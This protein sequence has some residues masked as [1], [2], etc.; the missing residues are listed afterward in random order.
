MK[1]IATLSLLVL[2]MF[3]SLNIV[4]AESTPAFDMSYQGDKKSTELETYPG[5]SIKLIYKITNMDEKRSISI[6]LTGNGMGD[7]PMMDDWLKAEKESETV[8]L[9]KQETELAMNISIPKDAKL[10][11]YSGS[12]KG[13][14]TNYGTKIETKV[15]TSGVAIGTAIGEQIYVSVKSKSEIEGINSSLV[16]GENGQA[17]G[18][19][20]NSLIN[21]PWF[22]MAILI[23]IMSILG[24]IFIFPRGKE[25]K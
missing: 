7:N 12:I 2:L 10:E 17:E 14:M 22:Q 1:K 18:T 23:I 20:G 21:K 6:K 24:A 16:S 15:A 8:I 13:L 9:P 4:Y 25:K 3:A 5:G 19:E 11:K